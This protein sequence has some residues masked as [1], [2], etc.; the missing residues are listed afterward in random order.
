MRK[1]KQRLEVVRGV[2]CSLSVI[3]PYSQR[4]QPLTTPLA[5]DWLVVVVVVVVLLLV[6]VLV[7]VVLLL[8]LLSCY[9]TADWCGESVVSHRCSQWSPAVCSSFNEVAIGRAVSYAVV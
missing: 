5:N 1:K 9:E 6:L 2:H 7:L 4:I 8:L 3:F